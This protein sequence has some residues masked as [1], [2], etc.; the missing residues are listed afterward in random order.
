M[1][2]TFLTMLLTGPNC[3]TAS[4]PE[5]VGWGSKPSKHWDGFTYDPEHNKGVHNR[6]KMVIEHG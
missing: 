6:W 2:T 1:F 5:G 4:L 3:H